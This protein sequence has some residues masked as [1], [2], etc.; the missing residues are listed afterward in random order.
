VSQELP[1]WIL[2]NILVATF[3]SFNV[4]FLCNLQYY[5]IFFVNKTSKISWISSEIDTYP[6][7][8]PLL[9][10]PPPR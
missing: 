1:F 4:N 9:K 3:Y 2:T 8:P 5:F 7:F 6:K 10:P